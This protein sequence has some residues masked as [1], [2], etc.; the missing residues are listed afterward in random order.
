MTPP[1]VTP[2]TVQPSTQWNSTVCSNRGR[3]FQSGLTT[4]YGRSTSPSAVTIRAAAAA[5]GSFFTLRTGKLVS[6]SKAPIATGP[7]GAT[8]AGDVHEREEAGDK[9][10][11]P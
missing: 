1:Q 11:T 7:G 5:S 8:D 3:R 9:G 10:A 2:G 6:R 4:R